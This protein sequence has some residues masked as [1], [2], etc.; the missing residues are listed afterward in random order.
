[1]L[2]NISLPI[3]IKDK[4][5]M[6]QWGNPHYQVKKATHKVIIIKVTS[7]H[8]KD[9]IN[10]PTCRN[11]IYPQVTF[12]AQILIFNFKVLLIKS[13]EIQ[14]TMENMNYMM[15]KTATTK[16]HMGTQSLITM[17]STWFI[18]SISS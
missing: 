14:A 1:M 7:N 4:Y 16:T 17:T 11:L 5:L 15:A 3:L 8:I 10:S 6:N 9:M 2:T 12:M 13:K 18:K